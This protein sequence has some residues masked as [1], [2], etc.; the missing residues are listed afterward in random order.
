MG[1]YMIS[2]VSRKIAR[3]HI[4]PLLVEAH[5]AG[6]VGED[7]VDGP[8]AD[9]AGAAGEAFLAAAQF[10]HQELPPLRHGGRGAAGPGQIAAL[11]GVV[12]KIEELLLPGAAEPDVFLVAVRQPLE[13]LAEEGQFAVEVL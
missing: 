3:Y 12:V 8:A 7:G 9:Q 13:G 11:L 2:F 4:C 1:T 6:E 10:L 5:P